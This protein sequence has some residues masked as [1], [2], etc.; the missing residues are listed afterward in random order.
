[1]L[2][3]SAVLE[4]VQRHQDE[5]R[6]PETRFPGRGTAAALNSQPGVFA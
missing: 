4:F 1:M 3:L 2:D 5:E 6:V